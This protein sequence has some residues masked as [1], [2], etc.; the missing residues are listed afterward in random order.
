[1]LL[2]AWPRRGDCCVGPWKASAEEGRE[3]S[4]VTVLEL[5]MGSDST[6][7]MGSVGVDV[8]VKRTGGDWRGWISKVGVGG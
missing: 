2:G 1:M 4:I 3:C 6:S 7:A 5:C 8:I